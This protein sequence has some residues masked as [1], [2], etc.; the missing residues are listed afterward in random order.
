MQLTS[1]E[2][3]L[4]LLIPMCKSCKIQQNHDCLLYHR[5][6]T[7]SHFQELFYITSKMSK[8]LIWEWSKHT[9][10]FFLFLNRMGY[11]KSNI[12]LRKSKNSACFKPRLKLCTITSKK[13]IVF[14]KRIIQLNICPTG[15][16]AWEKSKWYVV[17]L[18]DKY[19]KQYI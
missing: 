12:N 10:W 3:R 8:F 14:R 6:L 13:V 2:S 17:T 5:W 16:L 19:T 15:V 1:K 7:Q 9:I 18:M 4:R 11:S